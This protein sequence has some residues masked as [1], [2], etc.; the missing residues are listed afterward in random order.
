MVNDEEYI[1][2]INNKTKICSSAFN[3]VDYSND[4]EWR[5]CCEGAPIATIAHHETVEEFWK[6]DEVKEVRKSMTENRFHKVCDK[7]CY[8]HEKIGHPLSRRQKLNINFI[9]KYGKDS[10]EKKIKIFNDDKFDLTQLNSFEMRISNLCNLKCRMCSPK[11]STKLNK[12]WNEALPTIEKTTLLKEKNKLNYY[13]SLNK[14]Y[15]KNTLIRL[16]FDEI[17]QIFNIIKYDLK[18]LKFTGGEPFMDPYLYDAIKEVKD[19]AK[20]I[21]LIIVSNGTKLNDIEKFNN[22]F[23]EFKSTKFQLSCDG[24]ED[25]YEYIRQGTKWEIFSNQAISLQNYNYDLNF[26]FVIQIYNYNN[27]TKMINW[28]LENFKNA[29]ITFNILSDPWYL[30]IYCLP[31]DIKEKIKNELTSYVNDILN[32]NTIELSVK[33]S[34]SEKLIKI[35]NKISHEENQ[36]YLNQFAAVSDKYDEIQNVP[37]TWRQ[38]LPEL[39]ESLNKDF[40]AKRATE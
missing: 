38:L 17:K 33:K 24:I 12:D 36:K 9:E 16:K 34:I 35:V 7:A 26:H 30:S 25:T 4:G 2:H 40:Q 21:D 13:A 1:N 19:V 20:N 39:N 22:L 27:I 15:K 3:H 37:I 14:K 32:S 6:S 11:F 23:K 10:L 31:K 29:Q 18:K 8:K 5:L 28:V